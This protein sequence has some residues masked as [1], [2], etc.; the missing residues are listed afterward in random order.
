MY[1]LE[2]LCGHEY[3][4]T[5]TNWFSVLITLEDPVLHETLE[6]AKEYNGECLRSRGDFV[7]RVALASVNESCGAWLVGNH[8]QY[9]TVS[10]KES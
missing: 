10:H 4:G 5:V 7:S 9:R 6:A 3:D 8:N 1:H 2:I